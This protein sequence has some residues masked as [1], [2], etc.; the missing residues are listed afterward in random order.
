MASFLHQVIGPICKPGEVGSIVTGAFQGFDFGSP[1]ASTTDRP[2]ASTISANRGRIQRATVGGWFGQNTNQFHAW[3]NASGTRFF[4]QNTATTFPDTVHVAFKNICING[5]TSQRAVCYVLDN[6]NVLLGFEFQP[7]TNALY[8][9]LNGVSITG[10]PFTVTQN[11]NTETWVSA[12][13]YQHGSAGT[14]KVRVDGTTVANLTGLNTLRA[15]N[16]ADRIQINSSSTT[17]GAQFSDLVIADGAVVPF[18]DVIAPLTVTTVAPNA[19]LSGGWSNSTGSDN[20]ALVDERP[21]NNTD[22][23]YSD[24]AETE[25]VFGFPVWSGNTPLLVGYEIMGWQR[26]S[27]DPVDVTTIISGIPFSEQCVFSYSSTNAQNHAQLVK[28]ANIDPT[29]ANFSIGL[30]VP[31][32]ETSPNITTVR[33]V[34]VSLT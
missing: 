2:G 23:I 6:A 1:F 22:Y 9:T 30:K 5:T 32:G 3:N 7:N 16:K 34:I 21:A 12:V 17:V 20:V 31:T 14:L 29:L 19:V 25:V 4:S 8:V 27:A 26:T 24:V 10:S 33:Q 15:G 28:V 11:T 13:M 18:N